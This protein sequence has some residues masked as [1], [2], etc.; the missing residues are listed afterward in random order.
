MATS[1]YPSALARA[2]RWKA[3]NLS[4]EA[5]GTPVGSVSTNDHED[6]AGLLHLFALDVASSWQRRGIGSQLIYAV[7]VEAQRQ[8]LNGV[9]LEVNVDSHDAIRLY[10]RLGYRRE[11]DWFVNRWTDHLEHGSQLEVSEVCHRMFKRFP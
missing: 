3:R 7:E 5:N 4:G 1:G 2:T 6:F 9:Y 10:E 8:E 11:G